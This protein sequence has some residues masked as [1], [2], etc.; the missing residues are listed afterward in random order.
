MAKRLTLSWSWPT[1]CRGSRS[2]KAWRRTRLRGALLPKTTMAVHQTTSDAE[3]AY[4]RSHCINPNDLV[5]ERVPVVVLLA[6]LDPG[7]PRRRAAPVNIRVAAALLG[8]M[9]VSGEE[10]EGKVL[11]ARAGVGVGDGPGTMSYF[12][13]CSG[14]SLGSG[15]GGRTDVDHSLTDFPLSGCWW[16]YWLVVTQIT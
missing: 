9:R 11:K 13:T 12:G 1:A 5:H 14:W 3:E 6:V 16:Q 2:R 7:R 8:L 4:E 15:S 10:G